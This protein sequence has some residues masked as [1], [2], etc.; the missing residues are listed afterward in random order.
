MNKLKDFNN[1][2]FESNIKLNEYEQIIEGIDI[3][4]YQNSIKKFF[5]ETKIQ[6]Y[7]VL[8]F[9]T[10]LTVL[11]PVV[12]KF[13]KSGNFEIQLNDKNITLLT[14]YAFS[15]LVHESKEKLKKIYDILKERDATD[16]D[17]KKSVNILRNIHEL[18]KITLENTDKLVDNFL[19]MISYSGMFVPFMSILDSLITD[20]KISSELM[21]GEFKILSSDEQ[22]IKL[23]KYRILHKLD[24]ITKSTNKFQNKDN[25]KPLLVN[26]ELKSPMY[27]SE[28]AYIQDNITESVHNWRDLIDDE[29][30]ELDEWF[31]N[32]INK[33]SY[34][35]DELLL[36]AIKI[37]NFKWVKLLVEEYGAN[38]HFFNNRAVKIAVEFG[39]FEI[40]KYLIIKGAKIET[41][42]DNIK[43]HWKRRGYNTYID[44]KYNKD[45]YVLKYALI[46][47]NI[48][49][50]KFLID[51]G[52]DTNIPYVQGLF[53][54][55]N[56]VE[57]IKYI[58]NHGGDAKS[59][60]EFVKYGGKTRYHS[61]FDPNK[62]NNDAS[63][64]I[65]RYFVE[66]IYNRSN[67]SESIKHLLVGPT[68]EEVIK[69]L[70]ET[71]LK[72][73]DFAL[74]QEDDDL[75]KIAEKLITPEIKKEL[76][77][78]ILDAIIEKTINILEDM[79]DEDYND[80]EF[81]YDG[82]PF[83]YWKD[84]LIDK[85]YNILRSKLEDIYGKK[86]IDDL[87]E[88]VY[89]MDFELW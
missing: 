7:Y 62:Y 40:A 88:E 63:V 19:D 53:I 71:P 33:K 86:N 20:G 81:I 73:Y 4:K 38:I 59:Y 13:M 57:L 5:K 85:D 77:D 46:W 27:K 84:A 74:R 47:K 61:Y 25:I 65:R 44:G 51:I 45:N 55:Y 11:L 15:V 9:G 37:N 14:I 30:H 23:L 29:P 3:V 66:N 87:F 34:N 72:L 69:N 35:S 54:E 48:D 68:K 32:H 79:G 39:H 67:V 82:I 18:F 52:L 24:I 58:F 83:K 64:F 31:N 36:C 89:D 8:T 16:E 17:I 70:K 22:Q 2:V 80:D 50:V 21:S 56:D 6:L 43:H 41:F 42:V 49:F 60:Y 78:F 26:D 12:E 28:N 76:V 10:S 75:K 1:F